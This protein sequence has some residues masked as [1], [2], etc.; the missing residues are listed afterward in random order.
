M[1]AGAH[2]QGVTGMI[3]NRAQDAALGGVRSTIAA[4]SDDEEDVGRS[5]VLDHPSRWL[6]V[7]LEAHKLEMGPHAR[8]PLSVSRTTKRSTPHG[9]A[10]RPRT[11]G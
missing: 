6:G 8:W 7:Q 11:A 9:A 1:R 5:K 4:R 3:S 10:T 2:A